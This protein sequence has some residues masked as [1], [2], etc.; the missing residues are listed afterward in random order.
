MCSH[1]AMSDSRSKASLSPTPPL[2]RHEKELSG[3]EGVESSKGSSSAEKDPSTK[4]SEY[5]QGAGHSPSSFRGASP[6]V[7]PESRCHGPLLRGGYETGLPRIQ[8][9]IHPPSQLT[10]VHAHTHTRCGDP[11]AFTSGG[12]HHWHLGTLAVCVRACVHSLCLR[13]WS[14]WDPLE[15]QGLADRALFSSSPLASVSSLKEP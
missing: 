11:D 8:Q 9:R 6:R 14:Q 4:S 7:T 12:S 1:R 2:P 5:S 13:K 15:P 3:L 10:R